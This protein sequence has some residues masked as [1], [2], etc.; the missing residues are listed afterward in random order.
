MR[1]YFIIR[2]SR[3]TLRITKPCETAGVF[4][5]GQLLDE[6]ALK[7]NG[8][9]HRRHIANL[10]DRVI[11]RDLDDWQQ[12]LL[13]TVDGNFKCQQVTQKHLYEQLLKLHYHDHHSSAKW[14]E[15]LQTPVEWD[16]VWKSVHNPLFTEE[17]TSF[18]WEQIHL[19]MYTTHSYNKWHKTAQCCPLCA[20][21][22]HDEFHIIY[23]PL[24]WM[25]HNR[26]LNAQIN[27]IHERAL[28]IIHN[29]NISSFEQL[30]ILSGFIKIHHRKALN[31]LS[32][33]LMSDLFQVKDVRY[34]LRKGKILTSYNVKTRCYVTESITYLP[35]KICELIAVEIKNY[36]SLKHF[37]MHVRSWI[38]NKCPW[39]LCKEYVQHIGYI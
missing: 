24:I 32:S 1:S 19:N 6:V 30:L 16:K 20:Q 29:G 34:S 23:C 27:R 35:P 18:V 26:S 13:N 9:P 22:I 28:R 31:N 33:T 21:I 14:V 12:Y 7:N 36:K 4:T 17:T 37:K 5:Y 15:K 38:P 25:C 2:F 10:F 11:L 3:Q 39:H 8:R